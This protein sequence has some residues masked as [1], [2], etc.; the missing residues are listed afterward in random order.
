MCA[1]RSLY[2]ISSLQ[3]PLTF[4]GES[5]KHYGQH[6]QTLA[7]IQKKEIKGMT[8]RKKVHFAGYS[9]KQAGLA[10]YVVTTV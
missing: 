7:R 10:K 6:A 2:P 3:W 1:C 5:P 4:Q 9:E 8:R